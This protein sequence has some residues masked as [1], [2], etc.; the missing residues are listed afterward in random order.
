MGANLRM[1]SLMRHAHTTPGPTPIHRRVFAAWGQSV[2]CGGIK[3]RMTATEMGNIIYIRE[4][5]WQ[6]ENEVNRKTFHVRSRRLF[7]LLEWCD[8]GMSGRHDTV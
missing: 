7:C 4:K 3:S 1:Q 6:S 2:L 8:S 5:R